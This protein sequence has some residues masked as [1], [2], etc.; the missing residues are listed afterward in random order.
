MKN[1][2]LLLVPT[3]LIASCKSNPTNSEEKIVTENTIPSFFNPI[4]ELRVEPIIQR[5]STEKD[6]TL[7]LSSGSK[8]FIPANSFV[9]KDGKPIV[10]EVD[11][12]WKEFHSLGEVMLSGITMK[13]DSAGVQNDMITGGM[14]TIEAYQNDEK[15]YLAK[16]KK[17]KIDILSRT[18]VERMNFYQMNTTTNDWTY[19]QTQTSQ[20]RPL[21]LAKKEEVKTINKN[22]SLLDLPINTNHLANLKGKTIVAWKTKKKIS[23]EMRSKLSFSNVTTEI[24]ATK[25]TNEYKL[26]IAYLAKKDKI[27]KLEL[28]VTPYFL[29]EAM[30]NSKK[31]EEEYEKG[32][33]EI[34]DYKQKMANNEV[35]RSIEITSMGTYNWDYLYHRS[36]SKQLMCRLEFPEDVNTD[37]VNVFTIC[38]E[39]NAVVKC[40]FTE[41]GNYIYDPTKRNC[42]VAITKDNKVLFV[43]NKDF[44]EQR[45]EKVNLSFKMRTSDLVLKSAKDFDSQFH[46]FI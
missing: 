26:S 46:R 2:A 27:E 37:F 34:S 14:F 1:I 16:N 32:I 35:V 39:D 41:E 12:E 21:T 8:I 7:T 18:G 4:N 33:D 31:I 44:I 22:Y 19:K 5:F 15:L 3:L 20:T 45:D 28:L 30:L 6:K 29:E 10:G 24:T 9:D 11:L 40:A 42:I 17:L 38:P 25:D 36:C 23:S 13:Y 43:P